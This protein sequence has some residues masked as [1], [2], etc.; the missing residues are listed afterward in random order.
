L[1]VGAF[2]GSIVVFAGSVIALRKYL[3][4][5]FSVEW[6]KRIFKL[7]FATV[8]ANILE[9]LHTF[10]ERM[11]VGGYTGLRELG[12]Y[13]HSQQ[14]RTMSMMALKAAARTV[15]PITLSEAR[16]DE[17][18]FPKT[19]ETWD[20]IYLGL[21][22]LGILFATFGNEIISL[23][24]HGKFDGAYVFVVFWMVYLLIQN[25]GKP[26]TGVFLALNKGVEYSKMQMGSTLISIAMLVILVPRLGATGAVISLF[27][28]MIIFRIWIQIAVKKHKEIHSH[29]WWVLF[30]CLF[31]LTTF[32]I[33]RFFEFSLVQNLFLLIAMYI[34]L[35][36]SARRI[37]VGILFRL[38]NAL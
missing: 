26:H 3:F 33:S 6:A 30:G 34:A 35:G 27:A 16:A 9:T 7:G 37:I 17:F 29:D 19:R 10:V 18:D 24:T 12:I 31:I 25:A 14:Y 22:G 38:K 8:P 28:Q 4:G 21:A 1:F 32:F 15:Q 13:T 23:L 2:A 20:V 11:T 5:S 36:L